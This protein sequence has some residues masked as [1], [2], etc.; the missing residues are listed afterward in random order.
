M[1]KQD[2]G[3]QSPCTVHLEWQRHTR[4]VKAHHH[5]VVLIHGP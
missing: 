3:W 5:Q 1:K 4:V 2:I